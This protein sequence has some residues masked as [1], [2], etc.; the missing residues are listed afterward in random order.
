MT[1]SA[2]CPKCSSRMEA[3]FVLDQTHGGYARAPWV[4]GQPI[5]SFWTGLK[6]KDLQQFP[7]TTYRCNS[8]GFLE[9]FAMSVTSE[10]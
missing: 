10:K 3:G 8:C 5:P 6:V 1:R 2:N 9:S 4:P 7:V